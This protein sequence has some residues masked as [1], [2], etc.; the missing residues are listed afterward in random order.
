MAAAAP[1]ASGVSIPTIGASSPA[2]TAPTASSV[3]TA[4]SASEVRP[5]VVVAS[6]ASAASGAPVE[7]P[8]LTASAVVTT[9]LPNALPPIVRPA[10]GTGDPASVTGV[11]NPAV[12]KGVTVYTQIY[13]GE[14]RDAVRA[15]REDWRRLGAS[16]PPIEDVY[17]TARSKGRAQPL[18]V[19]RTTVRF[20]DAKYLACATQLGRSIGASDWNVEPLSPRLKAVPGVVEVWIAPGM[21]AVG[22][23]G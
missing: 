22:G 3:A 10:S 18:A 1:A 19:S 15:Y 23:K 13:G 8:T 4:A 20:H 6:A 9:G 2:V 21:Q 12:C 11:A 5:P 17:A 14:Q 7:P 16:V